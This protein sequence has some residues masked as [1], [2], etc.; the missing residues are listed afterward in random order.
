MTAIYN[1]IYT[2]RLLNMQKFTTA[3]YCRQNYLRKTREMLFLLLLHSA[4]K[5]QAKITLVMRGGCLNLHFLL[6]LHNI[7]FNMAT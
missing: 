3:V 2:V 1:S 7:L 6:N 4:H 5:E